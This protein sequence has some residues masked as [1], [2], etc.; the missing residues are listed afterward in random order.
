MTE[1]GTLQLETTASKQH[2]D[3]RGSET[4]CQHSRKKKEKLGSACDTAVRV[5]D[6]STKV[7]F[8]RIILPRVRDVFTTHV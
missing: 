8:H 1:Q 4:A 7:R 2:S 6:Q 3:S 5:F